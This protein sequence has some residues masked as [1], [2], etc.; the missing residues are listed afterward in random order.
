MD[1]S[2]FIHPPT[3][4]HLGGFQILVIML[5][6]AL[7]LHAGFCVDKIDSDQTWWVFSLR[8]KNI[9]NRQKG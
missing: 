7:D 1:H 8:Q 6:V 4:V 2:L 9:Y 3:E 5:K